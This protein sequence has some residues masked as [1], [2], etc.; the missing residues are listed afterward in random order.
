MDPGRPGLKLH[1]VEGAKDKGF[2]SA[3][4]SRDIRLIVHRTASSFLLCYVDHHDAAYQWAG[5]RRLERH[6][7]TGAAQLVEIRETVREIPVPPAT[8]R[9]SRSRAAS[10]TSPTRRTSKRS[11]APSATCSTSPARVPATVCW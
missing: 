11:T 7:T 6:P 10:S 8:T 1:E 2:W 9:S 5:R 4:V 3:R